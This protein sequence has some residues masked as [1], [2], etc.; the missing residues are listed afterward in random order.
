MRFLSSFLLVLSVLALSTWASVLPSAQ[1]AS[2]GG[3]HALGAIPPSAKDVRAVTIFDSTYGLR[4]LS[5]YTTPDGLAIIDGDII[6]GTESDL[7]TA[8]HA[9]ANLASDQQI[10]T[11][12]DE[13][14]FF[15]NATIRYAYESPETREVLRE[16]MEFAVTAWKQFAPYLTFQELPIGTAKREK[17]VVQV[18]RGHGG[19]LA[20]RGFTDWPTLT[21]GK[22]CGYRAA[23]HELG[24]VLGM[25]H[26]HQRPDR[27]KWVRFRCENVGPACKNMPAGRTCC[28]ELFPAPGGLPEGCCGNKRH[29]DTFKGMEGDPAISG[30]YDISSV[31][32]YDEYGFGFGGKKVLEMVEYSKGHKGFRDQNDFPTGEDA[33]RVCK[34]YAKACRAWMTGS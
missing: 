7:L 34:M 3:D 17:H 28:D 15:P 12:R 5:Y 11:P 22:G 26:E 19:C 14:S 6:Y 30:D 32:H 13:S 20:T 10:T 23:T 8:A 31:M 25:V 24:H 2:N 16:R 27:D 21:L 4:N 33:N 29:F 18:R 9:A 1:Q